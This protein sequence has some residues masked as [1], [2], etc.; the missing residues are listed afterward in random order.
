MG[1]YVVRHMCLAG[2]IGKS[3]GRR[4]VSSGQHTCTVSISPL[5]LAG[6]VTDASTDVGAGKPSSVK[7]H[8]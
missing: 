8:E 4:G 1:V 6:M 2:L 3:G 7:M 5:V